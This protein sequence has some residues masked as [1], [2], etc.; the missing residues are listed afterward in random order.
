MQSLSRPPF[1]SSRRP[2]PSARRLRLHSLPHTQ[3]HTLHAP[4]SMYPRPHVSTLA[5]PITAVT[6]L[7]RYTR[8]PNNI[9]HY[10]LYLSLGRRAMH[11]RRAAS[12]GVDGRGSE[13]RPHARRRRR[14]A[15]L[16]SSPLRELRLSTLH[17]DVFSVYFYAL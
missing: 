1:P 5:F 7:T 12:G 3:T 17:F 6:Q 14:A 4:S 16:P 2:A 10:I 11:A 9:T 8:G 13:S 15:P